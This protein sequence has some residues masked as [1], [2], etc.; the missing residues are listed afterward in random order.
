MIA[1]GIPLKTRNDI[2]DNLYD[3][4]RS[5]S[6]DQYASKVHDIQRDWPSV[7]T[8]YYMDNIHGK[9][10]HY[11]HWSIKNK[12]GKYF[13]EHGITTNQ[14]EFQGFFFQSVGN[15][16]GFLQL[17][18]LRSFGTVWES[19][20]ENELDK[21]KKFTLNEHFIHLKLLLTTTLPLILSHGIWALHIK[22]LYLKVFTLT[23]CSTMVIFGPL[24]EKKVLFGIGTGSLKRTQIHYKKSLAIR[25]SGCG[26][27]ESVSANQKPVRSSLY[28]EQ[29]EKYTILT[30]SIFFLQRTISG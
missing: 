4:L 28:T 18:K 26:E 25:C 23:V 7:I 27:L 17:G 21:L 13:T 20:K 29:H 30:S 22:C 8:S 5:R 1:E 15:G 11:G 16:A 6:A 2:T 12:F 10:E 9:V 3:L 19:L 14:S 24:L